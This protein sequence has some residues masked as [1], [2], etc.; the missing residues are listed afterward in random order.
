MIRTSLPNL[1]SGG[2]MNLKLGYSGS[3]CPGDAEN[4]V[5]FQKKWGGKGENGMSDLKKNRENWDVT[6]SKMKETQ[7]RETMEM[8]CTAYNNTKMQSQKKWKNGGKKNVV[9]R[10]KMTHVCPKTRKRDEM[11]AVSFLS[12]FAQ[13][14]LFRVA[15][16]KKKSNK[17][18]VQFQQKWKN[19]PKQHVC[20]GH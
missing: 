9:K 13:S 8:P 19:G 18:D 1:K 14:N 3:W 2:N 4:F 10:L 12:D 5:R 11:K 7:I 17:K 20:S 6:S 16:L 15:K